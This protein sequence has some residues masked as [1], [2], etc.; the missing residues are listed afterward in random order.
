MKIS[1]TILKPKEDAVVK[2]KNIGPQQSCTVGLKVKDNIKL[3]PAKDL[4]QLYGF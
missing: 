1:N 3:K 2:S 4:L